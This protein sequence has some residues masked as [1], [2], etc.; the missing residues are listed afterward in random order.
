MRI[1]ITLES[2]DPT[3]GGIGIYTEEIVR[4]LL[5]VDRRNEYI[6]IYPGFGSARSRCGRYMRKYSNAREIV[7]SGS[8][9]PIGTYWDQL[10][11]RSAAEK[12]HV[13]LL[14]NPFWSVP[15]LGHFKK[16]M[17]MHAVKRHTLHN[18]FD[19]KRRVEWALHDSLLLSAA[20]RIISISN[21]MTKDLIDY[22]HVPQAKIRMIYH[23]LSDKFAVIE[24]RERLRAIREE[25][26]LPERFILFVGH[27]YPQKNFTRLVEAIHLIADRVPH[28]LVVAGHPR[29][30][31]EE[32]M[33]R[34]DELGLRGRIRFLYFVEND[35]LPAIYNLADCFVLP[36][37]YEAFGL[38]LVEAMACGCPVAAAEAG[39]VPEVAGSAAILFDP[40]DP[41]AIAAA[42]L[43][44]LTDEET[45][46]SCIEKGIARAAEF[47]WEKCAR[48]T[49]ALFEELGGP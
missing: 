24:D 26:D 48:E 46:R 38:V 40:L 4:H 43:R 22:L 23:G 49:L 20:D 45:R 25:Y 42:L 9:L 5:R 35:D 32:S 15:V 36:S 37:L 1:G 39:A 6:L 2:L 12:Q 41:E 8:H 47:S 29:W 28:P 21:T 7:T 31:Y 33:R 19:W 13:D 16:V 18:V 3:W 10:I 44:L 11:V 14:F 27:I 30:Q 17:I 34:I